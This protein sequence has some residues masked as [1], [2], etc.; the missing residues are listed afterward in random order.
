MGRGDGQKREER[1]TFTSLKN[2]IPNIAPS[3][4]WVNV[5]IVRDDERLRDNEV[6][7]TKLMS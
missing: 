7:T 2:Y 4:H 5:M 1:A 6:I 3:T